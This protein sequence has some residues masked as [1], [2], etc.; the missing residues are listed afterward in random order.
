MLAVLSL[1]FLSLAA[2]PDVPSDG[3]QISGQPAAQWLAAFVAEDAEKRELR[4]SRAV[5]DLP[6]EGIPADLLP[7]LSGWLRDSDPE[8]RIGT[9]RLLRFAGE[10]KPDLRPILIERMK[11]EH[12]RVRIHAAAAELWRAP[13]RADPAVDILVGQAQAPDAAVRIEAFQLVSELA[14]RDPR[15]VDVLL[16]HCS[17]AE[18]VFRSTAIQGLARAR[19]PRAVQAL[20]AAIGDPE[21][22]IRGI[23][24]QALVRLGEVSDEVL[25]ALLSCARS[26]ESQVRDVALLSLC[27]L[28]N[29]RAQMGLSA[30]V[31]GLLGDETSS[32]TRARVARRI[33]ELGADG[34]DVPEAEP[35]LVRLAADPEP[36]AR[37][38]AAFAIGRVGLSVEVVLKTLEPLLIDIEPQPRRQA[39][40][41]L[42]AAGEEVFR[43]LPRLRTLLESTDDPTR[44]WAVRIIAQTG[45]KARECSSALQQRLA[46]PVPAVRLWAVYALRGL[47][48]DSRAALKEFVRLLREDPESTVR[49]EAARAL[50]ALGDLAAGA[51]DAVVAALADPDLEVRLWAL[52]TLGEIGA[53]NDSVR[54]VLEKAAKSDEPRE[55][56]EARKSLEKLF[57]QKLRTQNRRLRQVRPASAFSSSERSSSSVEKPCRSTR[58]RV[59]GERLERWTTWESTRE[60]AANG[61]VE[62][63]SILRKRLRR[64]ASIQPGFIS[65]VSSSSAVTAVLRWRQPCTAIGVTRWPDPPAIDENCS[66]PSRLVR[67][68]SPT[69]SSRPTCRTSPPSSVPGSWIRISG[70]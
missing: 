56:E 5:E 2:E 25:E 70:R 11:D 55:A 47:G 54:A 18:V 13:F 69:K 21:D 3:A 17:N 52:F 42:Q 37:A 62:G 49:V 40:E 34:Y 50:A 41:S 15:L 60:F 64:A 6:I 24:A 19:D 9:L 45:E 43:L 39:L 16:A 10:S 33:G 28:P 1:T 61:S 30:L 20:K 66:A 51:V 26:R 65:S 58:S 36:S 7:V 22:W 46:D 38:A 12:P 4:L 35:G 27:E 48:P 14:A 53:A 44:E 67:V 63:T 8:V 57:K 23:A 59:F 68:E 31:E 29:D 32:S